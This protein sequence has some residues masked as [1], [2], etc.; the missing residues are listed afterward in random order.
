MKPPT[1]QDD[2]SWLR[3]DPLPEERQTEIVEEHFANED[4]A[5]TKEDRAF[6]A[7]LWFA[8]FLLIGSAG[9][10]VWGIIDVVRSIG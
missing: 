5:D 2:F 3:D 9:L 6:Y 4:A 10:M 7:F 1:G 8:L